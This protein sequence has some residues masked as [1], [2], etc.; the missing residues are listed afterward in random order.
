MSNHR[1]PAAP[2]LHQR[3]KLLQ[4]LFVLPQRVQRRAFR[5]PRVAAVV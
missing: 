5:Q 4:R 3:L 2:P 1:V